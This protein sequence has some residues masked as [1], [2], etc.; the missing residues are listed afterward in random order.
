MKSGQLNGKCHS[1]CKNVNFS[2]SPTKKFQHV[3]QIT[4]KAN[5]VHGFLRCNLYR[6]PTSTKINCCKALVKPNL[7]YAAIIWLPYIQ[8]DIDKVEQV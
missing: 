2:G 4:N 6:C 3:K 5:R 8:K 7:E 1:I